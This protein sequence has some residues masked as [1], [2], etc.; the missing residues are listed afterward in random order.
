MMTDQT[1]EDY[2]YYNSE[3]QVMPQNHSPNRFEIFLDVAGP[4]F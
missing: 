3:T 1:N 4:I 2:F